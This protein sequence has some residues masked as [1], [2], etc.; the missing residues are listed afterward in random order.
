MLY[1]CLTGRPPFRGP[2]PLD[3][4]LAVLEREPDR[5][6]KCD[7]DLATIAM[8]CLNKEPTKRYDSAAAMA[9]DLDRWLNGEPIAARPLRPGESV[10]K[11]VKRQ[12]AHA[13]LI[14]V[15][16]CW[17]LNLRLEWSWIATLAITVMVSLEMCQ[18][19]FLVAYACGR[20]IN[21][22]GDYVVATAGSIALL[23]ASLIVIFYPASMSER[24][25]MAAGVVLSLWAAGFILSW[26]WSRRQAGPLL[27]RLCPYGRAI[28]F[29]MFTFACVMSLF[30]IPL[31]GSLSFP[32]GER[33]LVTD[34]IYWL[35]I[36]TI[37]PFLFL[38]CGAWCDIRQNGYLNFLEFRKWQDI[39]RYEWSGHGRDYLSLHVTSNRVAQ[40]FPASFFAISAGRKTVISTILE[41]H[42]HKR[43]S[44]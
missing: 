16:V 32:R 2:T 44:S 31:A 28:T 42:L 36:V 34:S 13:A 1:E 8:K 18:L 40:T 24:W 21:V 5:P 9:D 26:L 41:E 29:G 6:T 10:V 19:V 7:R 25:A 37:V 35:T 12:P 38:L 39:Q 15:L 30:A 22:P 4:L 43:N 33:N 11:W 3:T 27:I 14:V 20:P 23:P 17:I